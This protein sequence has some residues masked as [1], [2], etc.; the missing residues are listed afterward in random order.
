MQKRIIKTIVIVVVLVAIVHTYFDSIRPAYQAARL[1]QCGK[2]ARAVTEGQCLPFPMKVRKAYSF[3]L[4]D[5]SYFG[6]YTLPDFNVLVGDTIDVLYLPN[7]AH[8]SMSRLDAK[9][10]ASSMWSVCFS[11]K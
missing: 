5:K 2:S 7:N 1:L 11:G 4:N 6:H 3:K 10:Y 9:V 8:V